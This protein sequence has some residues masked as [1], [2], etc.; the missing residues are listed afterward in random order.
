LQREWKGDFDPVTAVS[1]Q[2]KECVFGHL[3][4]PPTSPPGGSGPW[5]TSLLRS[6]RVST[7]RRSP[8]SPHRRCLRNSSRAPARFRGKTLRLVG[9]TPAFPLI[10]RCQISREAS[11]RPTGTS[12]RPR[13]LAI[14]KCGRPSDMPTHGRAKGLVVGRTCFGTPVCLSIGS[15]PASVGVRISNSSRVEKPPT[16]RTALDHAFQVWCSDVEWPIQG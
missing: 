2:K 3:A 10:G 8:L 16:T 7:Q 12:R 6:S 1:V 14:P 4:I 11:L 9:P 13:S 5:A 15:E